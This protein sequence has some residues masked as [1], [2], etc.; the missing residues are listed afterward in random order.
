MNKILAIPAVLAFLLAASPAFAEVY[1]IIG[2]KVHTMGPR[3][4]IEPGTVLIEDGRITAVGAGITVPEGAT[5]IDASGRV[6]TPGLM[7]SYSHLGLVEIG[8]VAETVDFRLKDHELGAG[9]QAALG[10]NPASSLI[11]VTRIEG[12]T[13]AVAVPE[14]GVGVFAGQG[15][16]IHLGGQTGY[17]VDSSVAV[18]AVLGES[19][20]ELAGGARGAA[21]VRF[22]QALDEALYY[23]SHRAAYDTGSQRYH[24]KRLDL[25]A[26]V[27]VV[28]GLKPLAVVVNRASDIRTLLA[29]IRDTRVRLIL[30]S[31]VEGWKV[32]GEI[33]AAGVP[34]VVNPIENLPRTFDRLEATYE[35]AARLQAAGVTVA[36]TA[37]FSFPPG[38][39]NA[40]LLTQ[41]AGIAVS[42]GL[43]W[44]EALKAMTVNPARIWGLDGQYGT[45]EPGREADVVVWS[46][47][48]FELTT[49]AERVFI[50]GRDIP[51]ESR[52][53]KLRDRYLNLDQSD[54]PFAY[55]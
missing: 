54:P 19:G 28:K 22:Q 50:R 38:T 36:F 48:P 23:D 42:Y 3:G 18:F 39:H 55:R 27:P 46:G 1:A 11:P 51:L 2:G 52:Q 35:N 12:I 26:L 13:R 43:P 30:L 49:R 17:L 37:E 15:A 21:V 8:A 47:D 6:V 40:R 20:G 4:T 14:A 5:R 31:A 34:V 24:Y 45:L 32:A 29:L 7:D 10:L 53:T 25:E 33:A 44:Q 16:V 9:F 41:L